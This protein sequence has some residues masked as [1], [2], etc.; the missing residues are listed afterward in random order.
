MRLTNVGDYMFDLSIV[1]K[2]R[3]TTG[4]K[5]LW[6]KIGA[7]KLIS[8]DCDWLMGGDFNKIHW[9]HE[10]KGRGQFDEQGANDFN[11]VVS[12][13]TKLEASGEFFT[14]ANSFGPNT[15]ELVDSIFHSHHWLDR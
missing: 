8:D 4:R 6:E 7:A 10:H 1:Y 13:L 2:E 9:L 5:I 3:D 11:S 12:T 15:H 14:L